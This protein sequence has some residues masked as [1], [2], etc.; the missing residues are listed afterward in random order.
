[1]SPLRLGVFLLGMLAVFTLCLLGMT[2]IYVNA[3]GG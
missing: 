3:G 2:M 1:M